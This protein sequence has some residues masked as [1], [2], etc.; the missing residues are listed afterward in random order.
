MAVIN[1]LELLEERL[2]YRFTARHYLDEALTHRSFAN[3][4][5]GEG[6]ADNERLE[7]LGDAVLALS[8]GDYLLRLWPD[9]TEGTL[10]QLR[11]ELVN[12][13]RL[14]EVARSLQLGDYLRLGRG[15]ARS[16]G[17]DKDNLLADALEALIGAIFLDSGYGSVAAVIERLFAPCLQIPVGAAESDSKT[18]LQE[19]LQGSQQ[20]LPFYRLA[21]T[22]GPDHQ[23]HYEVEVLVNDQVLGRGTGGSKKRAEQ[24][25][26]SQALQHLEK[27][28]P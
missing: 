12:A 9:A 6:A 24:A 17:S 21:L 22:S 16:G 8:I 20:A 27:S 25:A 15:E 11:A 10:T 3:E 18:R 23:R 13:S 1:N 28:V 26:A 2:D 4:S 5:I 7:F 19:L 14:A